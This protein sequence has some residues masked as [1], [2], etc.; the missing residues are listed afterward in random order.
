[1][2]ERILVPHDGSA[3]ADQ[4]VEK[5]IELAR[6]QDA[7]V[8]L[9]AISPDQDTSSSAL[10]V[11]ARLTDDLIAFAHFGARLGINIDGAYLDM[12][13]EASL[14]AIIVNQNIDRVATVRDKA[15]EGSSRSG[16]LLKALAENCPVPVTVLG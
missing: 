1:M 14:H 2:S 6:T 12:P 11:G 5:A 7:C 9:L 13:T 15:T 8:Y 10:A 16:Q 3:P 4:A